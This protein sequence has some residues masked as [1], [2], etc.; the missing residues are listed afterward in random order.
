MSEP[1]V[2]IYQESVAPQV[3]YQAPR[4][5]EPAR[6]SAAFYLGIAILVS[7]AVAGFFYVL[8]LISFEGA[9]VTFMLALLALLPVIVILALIRWIDQWEPEPVGLYA[10]AFGWGA[11]VSA[12][13]S[14]VGNAVFQDAVNSMHDL[15]AYQQAAL[16]VIVGAPLIEEAAKGLGVLLVFYV[17]SRYF[18]G[19]VDGMVY[20]MLI[21]LGFAFT[22]NIFYFGQFYDELGAVFQAR[23]I[24]SPFIHPLSTAMTGVFVGFATNRRSG[25]AVIPLAVSGYALAVVLHGLHNFS[26]VHNI[27]S[28]QRLLFQLPVY[29][30]AIYLVTYLR[31]RERQ[32]V[33]GALYDY[34]QAGWITGN[35]IAMIQ[36][37]PNRQS[38]IRWAGENV[39]A[40]GGTR[41]VG[42]R[43]M[44]RFQAELIELGNTRSRNLHRA[45]V[46]LPE[47]R[48]EEARRLQL[49]GYLR[50]VF[51]GQSAR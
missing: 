39:A 33:T 51:T 14:I 5:R 50:E 9:G 28:V 3:S 24:E 17:F 40:L 26:A 25:L 32:R 22:E 27:G 47:S 41:E 2:S 42:Q 1:R 19:P 23:A 43:A 11:G 6:H 35:E 20:G 15:D 45:K 37:I 8:P 36:T 31:R 34:A 38:A 46:H 29:I 30:G 7:V 4:W 44:R 16:P 13:M 48:A 12:L 49:I 21:G 10:V 18:N